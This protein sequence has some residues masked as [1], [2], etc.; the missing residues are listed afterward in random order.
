M[1]LEVQI[2]MTEDI[3]YIMIIMMFANLAKLN[4]ISKSLIELNYCCEMSAMSYI[5]IVT[6]FLFIVLP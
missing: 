2:S 3:L 5:Q 1:P 4:Y 6:N